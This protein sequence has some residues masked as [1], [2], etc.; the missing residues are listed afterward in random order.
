MSNWRQAVRYR[1]RAEM[2]RTI[3]D[4][5]PHDDHKWSLRHMADC[6]EKM[7]AFLERDAE[8]GMVGGLL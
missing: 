6:Y 3:A 8:N 2:L 4:D 1:N 5:V 7:A